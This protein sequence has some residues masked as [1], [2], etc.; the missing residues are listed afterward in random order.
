MKI[1]YNWLKSYL[2]NIPEPENLSGVFASSLC[3]VDSLDKLTNGDYIFDLKIL[4]DRAHDLL[5]HQ[6][7]ARELSSLLDIPFVDPTP[8]YKIPTSKPTNLEIKIDTNMCR[9]Y[10]GRIVRNVK[11]EPS[12]GWVKDYLES[13]G[14]RS[15]N[16]IVDASNI[17]MFDSGQPTHCF[18]LDKVKGGITIRQAKVGERMITL[19]NKEVEL[20]PNNMVIADDEGVLAIAGVKGGK[21]AEVDE[22]TKNI[23]I[24]VANFDPISVR[25][26]ARGINILTDASKRFEN[27]PTSE[28][29]E[30]AMRELS[31][32]FVEYGFTDFEEV[33]DVYP[34]K[35][36][37]RS[38]NFSLAKISK[39]LGLLVSEKQVEDILKRYNF[40][41]QVQGDVYEIKV[42]AHRLD[43]VIEEDMAEEIGRVLGYDKVLPKLPKIEFVPKQNETYLKMQ[44]VR[45]YLL[46]QGY[47]EVMTYAFRDKGEV[48][49][50]ASASD[51]KFLRT[52]LS[53][54]LSVSLKLNK[55]NAPLLGMQEIKVFEIGTVFLKESE[56]IH[57]AYNEKDKV[58]EKSLD[59]FYLSVPSEFKLPT[60]NYKP[61]T[62]FTTWSAFPFISRD[63]ALWV[64]E[65]TSSEEV[66][67]MIEGEMG[68][69]VVRGPELFDTFAKNGRVSFAFRLVFQSYEKTLTDEEVN[70][71]MLKIT[72]RIK[73]NSAWELR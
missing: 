29:C 56:Q 5:S 40:E 31:G 35:P 61:S 34:K 68:E 13:L 38:L 39:I 23:I 58:I 60:T 59:E 1:S 51:K 26:T 7:I 41:F 73:A 33:V 9:R 64:P 21:K 30:Y 24:E 47:N 67:K 55:I 8:Q 10:M 6:G 17:V 48:E 4:P 63:I 3:E 27:E 70:A 11:V 18:D 69:L 36:A 22:N 25:K 62:I 2:P 45:G 14:Q 65:G 54:G 53:D 37:Q 16:N 32:L 57:V 44:K 71:Q 52:N 50:L 42:P 20:G 72:N 15:I 19:D 46:S 49:V 43:L 12:Q 28:L 66:K